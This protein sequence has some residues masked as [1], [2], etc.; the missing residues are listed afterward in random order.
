M[1]NGRDFTD[2]KRVFQRQ[3]TAEDCSIGGYGDTAFGLILV[4]STSYK[5]LF[6]TV[7][8]T[9]GPLRPLL[10]MHNS[11]IVCNNTLGGSIY[12]KHNKEVLQKIF[13]VHI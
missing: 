10:H 6:S 8:D 2:G 5:N 4:L 13:P 7:H 12:I 1:Q 3:L 11:H 9:R